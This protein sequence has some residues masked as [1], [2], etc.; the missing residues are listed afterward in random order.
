MLFSGF[1][2]SRAIETKALCNNLHTVR[3]C[4]QNAFIKFENAIIII[5]IEKLNIDISIL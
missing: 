2:S 4:Q 1:D 3:F 5:G